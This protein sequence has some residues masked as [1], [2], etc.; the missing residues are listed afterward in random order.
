M[1]KIAHRPSLYQTKKSNLLFFS[2]VNVLCEKRH[3][4]RFFK[5][6]S[7]H[8][9]TLGA[10]KFIVSFDF[11]VVHIHTM[12]M[13]TAPRHSLSQP[14]KSNLLFLPKW[15]SYAKNVIC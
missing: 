13:I 6:K 15:R 10:T 14:N 9:P 7:H 11:L 3:F 2:Q 8:F 12:L 4:E 1:M 5:D